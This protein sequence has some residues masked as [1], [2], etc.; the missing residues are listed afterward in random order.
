LGKCVC[1]VTPKEIFLSYRGGGKG[2]VG[3]PQ[4]FFW[5]G[6]GGECHEAICNLCFILMVCYKNQAISI[7][8][9]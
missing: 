4:N 9:I 2:G 7:T 1:V 5:G 3:A 8:V 6:G